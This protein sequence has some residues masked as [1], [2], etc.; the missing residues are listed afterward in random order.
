MSK[1][2]FN[3]IVAHEW[4]KFQTKQLGAYS[5]GGNDIAF[6][7]LKEAEGFLSYVKEQKP[8]HDWNIYGLVKIDL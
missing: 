4:Q 2:Q 3:Y 1:E 5:Y 7:T 8:E 6:G